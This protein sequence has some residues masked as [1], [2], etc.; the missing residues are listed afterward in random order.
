MPFD[1]GWHVFVMWVC[2]CQLRMMWVRLWVV[3]MQIGEHQ[4]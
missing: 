2:T 1:I 4:A 3:P